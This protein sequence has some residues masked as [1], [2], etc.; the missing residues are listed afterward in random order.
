MKSRRPRVQVPSEPLTF[1]L[2][3][4]AHRF[5]E[6]VAIIEPESGDRQWTYA[7]LEDYSSILAAS[8]AAHGV[9][10]GDRVALWFKNSVE[11]VL[12]F[13]GIMKAGGVVVPVSTHFGE[14]ELAHQLQVTGAMG[15]ISSNSSLTRA[16]TATDRLPLRVAITEN[17]DEFV[18]PGIVAFSTLLQGTDRIDRSLGIDPHETLAVLPFSSGTTGLP[19]GVMLSHANLLS[20]LYQVEQAQEVGHDDLMLNQLPFFHIYGMTVLFGVAIL[21]GAAQILAS[22]FRPVDEFLSLFE[23]FH[24]TLFF[25]V[26]LILQEF[27]HH[28]KVREMD[29]SGLRYINTG[30]APLAPELQERFTSLTGV[31]VIQ[32]YGLTESSP[33]THVVPLDKIKVGS[34]GTPVSLT[35]HKIVD[36]INSEEVQPG[37][38]GELWVRGPQVMR[39]YYQDSAATAHALV[40]GWLRTGDIGRQDEDG[41]VY[42]VD[43]LKELIKC[44]GFQVAPAEI[45]HVL[46][47]HPDILDAAVIGEAHP[48]TG[49]TP[50]AY[51]VIRE[52]STLSPEAI[53]DYAASGMA[54][55][56]RLSRVI[57]TA[58]IPRSPSGKILRRVLKEAHSEL[59][60]TAVS[61]R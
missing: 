3:Q 55:Y 14:R 30:G 19:K 58:S 48:E 20:N 45:E 31:P 2:R 22:R 44:K 1:A 10:P 12:S 53:I 13:Y 11:Y 38:I 34:I 39:G 33:T 8:L 60:E 56:K 57:L 26:P 36:P 42:I 49:E 32:G 61:E 23:R 28:P 21:A 27:C 54:K 43:R 35:E 59:R 52:G 16:K 51:A 6:K 46:H 40:N 50:V 25:T 18:S 5:P 9:S 37:Q 4:A 29:W 17:A 41:Y 7:Q 47:G 24:P 15:L